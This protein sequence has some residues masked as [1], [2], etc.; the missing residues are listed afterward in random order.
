MIN[1]LIIIFTMTLFYMG[2]AGRLTT[3]IR[4]LFLQGLLLFGVAYLEL[5]DVK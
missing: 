4:V 5:K 2:A 3:Y 1:I